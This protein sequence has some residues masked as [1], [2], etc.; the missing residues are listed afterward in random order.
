MIDISCFL[1]D[2]K[3]V[4]A[5]KSGKKKSAKLKIAVFGL[6]V[7]GIAT[8]KALVK[9]GADVFVWDD[10]ASK[11]SEAKKAGGT[12]KNLYEADF[13]GFDCLVLSPGVPVY[14]PEPH[15]VVIKAREAELEIISD[16]EI[17]YRSNLDRQIIAITGTNGKSTT[18]A[19]IAHILE[20]CG[21]SIAMGG[22]IGK[23]A[24]SLNRP[25]KDGFFVLEISSFQMDISPTFKP[26]IGV[27]LNVT[28]DHIDRHGS[29][30]NYV[31]AKAKMIESDRTY[32]VLGVDDKYCEDLYDR[33]SKI[34]P[35]S[36]LPISVTNSIKGGI[37]AKGGMLFDETTEEKREI[38]RLDFINL[39]GSHNHQNICAAYAVALKAGLDSDMIIDAISTFEGLEHRQKIARIINGIPYIND[40]KATNADASSKALA[41]Y[42]NIFWIAGGRMKDSKLN[43]IENFL[44]NINAAYLIGEAMEEFAS[45]L[46]GYG[47]SVFYSQN[48][49]NAVRQAHL[50]AQE[51]RG[52]PGGVPVVLFSPACASFDQFDNFEHRGNEF[53]R[54]VNS[55]NGEIEEKT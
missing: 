35:D 40:S 14:Y 1:E 55:L 52:S 21:Q 47:I 12:A 31:K 41:C 45:I 48:L 8:V 38:T 17:L 28:E 11:V 22:N 7:S 26:D 29:I 32:T 46:K 19:L 16:I 5:K 2:L 44:S 20:K 30:E 49:E 4:R 25:K 24:L 39:P 10:N 50:D 3:S 13:N 51:V 6:G 33:L 18:T 23:P 54:L 34:K 15:S 37:Y 53:I 9:G 27:M 36:M 42:K 43:G